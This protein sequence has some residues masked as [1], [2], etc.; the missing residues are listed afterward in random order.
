MYFEVAIVLGGVVFFFLAMELF[1][2]PAVL[3]RPTYP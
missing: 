3:A 1:R 2:K